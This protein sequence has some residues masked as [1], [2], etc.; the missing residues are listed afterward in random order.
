MKLRIG[1]LIHNND[2][3]DNLEKLHQLHLFVFRF[4]ASPQGEN[5]EILRRVHIMVMVMMMMVMLVVMMMVIV[6]MVMMVIVMMVTMVIVVIPQVGLSSAGNYS[7]STHQSNTATV[8][9]IVV[10]GNINIKKNHIK[11]NN[12]ENMI[13]VYD[14]YKV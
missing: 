5:R 8:T 2:D 10:Q 11:Y 1:L 6:V 14:L 7:C 9:I 3:V 12:D 4:L 13:C